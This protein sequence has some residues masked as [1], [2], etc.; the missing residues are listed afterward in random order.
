LADEVEL[1][2]GGAGPEVEEV[3][4]RRRPMVAVHLIED[5]NTLEPATPG[6]ET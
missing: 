2:V 3:R 5:E 6:E 1:L 4:N